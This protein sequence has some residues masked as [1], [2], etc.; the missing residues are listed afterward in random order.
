MRHAMMAA[1][2]VIVLAAVGDAGQNPG[3]PQTFTPLD[4]IEIQQLAIRYA[5]GLDTAADNG[6]MYDDV[7][8]P[9]GEFVGRQVQLTQGHVIAR[10]TELQTEMIEGKPCYFRTCYPVTIWPIELKPCFW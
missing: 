5:Y 9:D 3:K 4:Y 6:Y 10:H 8:T 1:F 2:G 7:F